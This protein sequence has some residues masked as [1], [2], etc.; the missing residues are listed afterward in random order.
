MAISEKIYDKSPVFMQNT[1]CSIKGWLIKRRR[2][3][4]S[5]YKELFRYEHGLYD[6]AKELASFLQAVRDMP[7]Y[8]RY[9]DDELIE[10]V[11]QGDMQPMERFPIIDKT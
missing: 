5:F 8:N 1:M 10:K 7:Q 6:G 2:Y 11:A 3:N 4:K 9:I